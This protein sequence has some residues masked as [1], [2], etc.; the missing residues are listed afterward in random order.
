MNSIRNPDT[1]DKYY[2]VSYKK[3][4]EDLPV[5][6]VSDRTFGDIMAKLCGE[7]KPAPDVPI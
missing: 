1:Y 4:R 2:L 7:H 6:D 5:I 3:R